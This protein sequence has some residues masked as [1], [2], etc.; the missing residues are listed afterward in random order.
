MKKG[1]VRTT[2]TLFLIV[3]FMLLLYVF[4]GRP[5]IGFVKDPE[6]LDAFVQSKGTAGLLVFGFFVLIQTMS[7]CIPG[8]PFY[9][10]S[11]YLLGG[12]KG[13]LLCDTFATLGNTAAFLIG[14][15]FGRDFLLYLFPE[16]KLVHVENIIKKGKPK[17]IHILFM[18]LPL[19][20]DTYAWLGYYSEEPLI[21][22]IPLTFIARFPHIFL[23]T[24]GAEQL[25]SN[26]YMVLILGGAFA[27]LV[28]AVVLM[29][30]KK[31]N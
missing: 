23:Y 14:K 24:Y 20:K 18:L 21:M 19:P 27:T 25:M 4:V 16:D 2:V 13:A 28:Y 9:L 12:F 10:A 11:G 15:K 5:M 29:L 30:L 6:A 22:W 17:I 3:I 7:S 31:K 26:K 8:L 1:T